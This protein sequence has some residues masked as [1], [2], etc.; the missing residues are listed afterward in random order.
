MYIRSIE[1]FAE[2]RSFFSNTPDKF[3]ILR[4]GDIFV[5]IWSTFDISGIFGGPF[6]IPEEINSG[7]Y[8]SGETL[9]WSK[10]W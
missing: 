6:M 9:L 7:L 4:L 5:S 8:L 3:T 1:V 10:V 2:G